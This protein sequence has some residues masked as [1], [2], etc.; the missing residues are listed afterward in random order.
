MKLREFSPQGL[1]GYWKMNEGTGAAIADRSVNSNSGTISGAAWVAGKRLGRALHFGGVND[2][3]LLDTVTGLACEDSVSI[4]AWV[5]PLTNQVDDYGDIVLAFQNYWFPLKN[6]GELL[7]GF[8]DATT[9]R[10]SET[11]TVL[12]NNKWQHVVGILDFTETPVEVFFYVDGS[13]D[14]SDTLN[15]TPVIS[16]TVGTI[17]SNDGTTEDIKA[18]LDEVKIYNRKLSLDE[19]KRHYAAGKVILPK[20]KRGRL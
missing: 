18:Y 9:W 4:E 8:R 13:L 1:V 11:T 17:G 12:S 6:T 20:R 3:V 10:T 2:V 7:L 16:V 19:V 15:Y 14:K 5:Y